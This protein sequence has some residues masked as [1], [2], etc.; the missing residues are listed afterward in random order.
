MPRNIKYTT[1]E[2]QNIVQ[3][4]LIVCEDYVN[5]H[6]KILH[7]CKICHHKWPVTPGAIRNGHGCPICYQRSVSKPLNEVIQKLK[8]VGWKINDVNDY[9]NSYS[10]IKLKCISCNELIIGTI[11]QCLHKSRKCQYCFPPKQ[12]KNWSNVVES[13]G[14]TYASKLEM[15]CAEF[16]IKRFGINDVILQKRYSLD[17]KM[18]ADIYIKSLDM[19]IEVSSINKDWYLERIFKKRKLVNNFL[20][21]ST[22][23]QLQEFLNTVCK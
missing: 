8:L 13:S 10:R 2:Y 3:D 22:L 5:A 14:R 15:Q 16:V 4:R 23:S 21:V 11:D 9:K 6:T 7:Q 20:F 1:E 19:Y 12:K 17:S 18:T